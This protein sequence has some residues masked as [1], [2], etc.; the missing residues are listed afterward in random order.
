MFNLPEYSLNEDGKTRFTQD[1]DSIRPGEGGSINFKG[2][3][4]GKEEDI[5]N[6][7]LKNKGIS[8][9][10]ENKEIKRVIYVPNRVINIVV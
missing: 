2:V 4:I 8:T 7:A 5:K 6:L 9:W 3:L 10:I 1:I